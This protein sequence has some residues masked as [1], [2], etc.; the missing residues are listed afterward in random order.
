MKRSIWTWTLILLALGSIAALANTPPVASFE[1]WSA[2][3]ASASTVVLDASTSHDSDGSLV[4]YGWNFGD[5]VSGTGEVVTHTYP[6]LSSYTVTLTV[7][8]NQGSAHVITR[9]LDFAVPPPAQGETASGESA[10]PAATVPE[11]Q[12][13]SAPIG[14]RPGERAPEF[15]L[16]NRNNETVRLSD[17]LGQ[18]VL[19]E[20]WSSSCSACQA[21]L[22]HLEELR[23][24]YSGQGM[25]VIALSINRYFQGE[26]E[27]LDQRGY[28]QF[29]VLGEIDPIN[30]PTM[31]MYGVSRI[32][33]AFLIDRTGV[34]RFSGHLNLLQGEA[35]EPW[36]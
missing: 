2:E 24:R 8:D 27:Y 20:F 25:V 32:P 30:K 23:A 11:V 16:P 15:A 4:Y 26:I 34:I 9:V 17:F 21:A 36:L 31:N 6:S 1:I 10:A 22:P 33:H 5:S 18:V 14:T 13:S 12:P 28:T 29:V 35:I 7:I 3:G 19:L